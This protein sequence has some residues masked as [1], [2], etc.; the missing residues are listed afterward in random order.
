MPTPGRERELSPDR[1]VQT[2]ERELLN[3][4]CQPVVNDRET[5]AARAGLSTRIYVLGG[6][7]GL[8]DRAAVLAVDVHLERAVG[9]LDPDRR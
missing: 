1:G 8:A 6:L 5:S 2:L 7:A 4:E 9:G 3:H